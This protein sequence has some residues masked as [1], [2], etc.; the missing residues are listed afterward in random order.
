MARFFSPI[1]YYL[2][3]TTFL[4]SLGANSFWGVC[5]SIAM[6]LVGRGRDI[7]Y[8]V[9][10]SFEASTAPLVGVSLRVEG[11]HHLEENRPATTRPCS[12]FSVRS[13]SSRTDSGHSH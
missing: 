2:R 13:R 3:L 6:S 1:R 5:V 11:R 10:R 12:T 8:V 9:A 7:N 4:V